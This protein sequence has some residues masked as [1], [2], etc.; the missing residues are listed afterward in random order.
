[1]PHDGRT[2]SNGKQRVQRGDS[3]EVL[4]YG[5][6]FDSMRYR[7]DPGDARYGALLN[8]EV[9]RPIGIQLKGEIIGG[10]IVRSGPCRQQVEPISNAESMLT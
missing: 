8:K 6:R 7:V 10:R 2:N 3:V 9:D 1:M 5:I 4:L